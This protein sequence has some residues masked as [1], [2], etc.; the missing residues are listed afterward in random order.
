MSSVELTVALP[1]YNEE[2]ILEHLHERLTEVLEATGLRYEILFVDDGSR[3]RTPQI[4]RQLAER[5]AHLTIVHLSRNWGHASALKAAID[6]A[7]GEQVLLMDAD[8]QDDPGVIPEILQAQLDNDADVVY[9]QRSARGEARWIR[10]LFRV[11]HWAISSA[12]TYPVPQDAGSFGLLGRRA[13]PEV[14]ALGERLRYFPGLRAFV[15]FKQVAVLAPR[16]A[17]YDEKSR[18]GFGG[19]V[20]LA[21]QA[22]FSQSRLPATC[23]YWLGGLSLVISFC[24]AT[25]ALVAKIAGFAVLSWA[26]ITTSVAFFSSVIILGLALVFEYLARIYEEVRARPVYLVD[27]VQRAE[28]AREGLPVA[29]EPQFSRSPSA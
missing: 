5:D 12:S 18:V 6:L 9:V 21:A 20:Q 22:F 28:V 15:G 13:L 11:F 24:L 29:A 10:G 3:D 8:L 4:M 17:R 1:V 16:Q 14:R 23:F 19:L 25:Y 2:G 7:A 27:T 26:S